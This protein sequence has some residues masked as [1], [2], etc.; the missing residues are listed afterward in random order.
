MQLNKQGNL[1]KETKSVII[2]LVIASL[3]F[4]TVL[5][6]F[7]GLRTISSL[8]LFVIPVFLILDNFDFSL[9]EKTIFSF[10]L[11]LGIY[12]TLVYYTAL[13]I[14]SIKFAMIIVFVVLT[15]AGLFLSKFKK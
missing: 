3:I 7:V 4:F 10:F 1:D 12:S 15:F 14:G 2:S 13:L 5:F 9:G 6:G 11:G 8:A